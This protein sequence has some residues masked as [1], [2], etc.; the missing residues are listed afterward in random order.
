MKKK[1][2][3]LLA[4]V[5][6]VSL[7]T[8]CGSSGKN[9]TYD[10]ASQAGAA[11]TTEMAY[12]DAYLY[13]AG[14]GE[15][16]YNEAMPAEEA[17]A[18]ELGYETGETE[19][20]VEEVTENPQAGRK[21][22]TTMNL[23]AE[24]EYFDTL[25]GNLEK[26]VNELGGYIE[27]SNQ[28]NGSVDYYGN[29]INNRNAYL[30]VRIPA[31]KLDSFLMMME[32]NSNIT[33]KSKNVEDVTLAYVDLESH[34]KALLTEEERLLELLEMAE[35]VEDLITI[36][37]KLAN[38]RYQLESM[39]SQLRTYDNKI[40]YSTVYLDIQEVERLTPQEEPTA[41]GRIKSG[42]AENV[43]D[44][45][46]SIQNFF[47]NLIISIPYILLWIV[48]LAVVLLIVVL[49]AKRE[50]KKKEKRL[51]KKQ[52]MESEMTMQKEAGAD[53]DL[54]VQEKEQ[55]TKEEKEREEKDDTSK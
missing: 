52:L 10:T 43:Y 6:T 14:Y 13:D 9:M 31:E 38:V 15:I 4:A 40:N 49:L 33:S 5:I 27:N 25:M 12:D 47:I 7:L 3:N 46:I 20:K 24:T 18:E 17:L 1:N 55:L 30:T 19:T 16:V 37:D 42:F 51:L 32:E 50:K 22:I 26:K 23:S 35:T 2:M 8:G 45:A 53:I 34:K 21:L 11:A 29:R 39:E 44:V 28:W 54:P 36:E 41:W 48:I